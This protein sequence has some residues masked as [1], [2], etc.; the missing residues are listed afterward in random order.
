MR[1]KIP[2]KEFLITVITVVYNGVSGIEDTIKSV[3]KNKSSDVEYV[4]IDGG[5]NDGT[6]D[7]LKK[8]AES[9]DYFVSEKDRGIYD[10]MNKGI[11][12]SRGD[13]L[14]FLNIGDQ[15]LSLPREDLSKHADVISG[16]VIQVNDLGNETIYT[17][18]LGFKSKLKNFLHHQGTFYKREEQV[19]YSLKY[20][21]FS[22]F[23]LN[24]K[25]FNLG[26]KIIMIEGVV[27]RHHSG[28]VSGNKRFFNENYT[29]VLENGN[30]FYVFLAFILN[31]VSGLSSRL[32]RILNK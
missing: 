28:G 9:I 4:V 21:V 3:I 10:A 27:A 24:L 22:D 20:D 16:K 13:W 1:N 31:K 32:N 8:Y 23:D 26:K 30:Y 11:K 25:L 18:R 5:S 19:R 2:N 29:I 6:V 17:P 7:I 15:L 12:A 14:Y